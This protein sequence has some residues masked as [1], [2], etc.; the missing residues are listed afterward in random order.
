MKTKI[1][2]ENVKRLGEMIAIRA[3]KTVTRYSGNALDKLY[4]GLIKDINN[5][6][7]KNCI[8]SDG[9]DIAQTAICFLCEHI[10]KALTD[11]IG[12]KK[13][14]DIIT[15]IKA[16]YRV[17]DKYITKKRTTFYETVCLDSCGLE[18]TVPFENDVT[19]TDYSSVDETIKKM[20]LT[21]RQTETL[22]YCMSGNSI[23]ET[24]RLLSLNPTTVWRS[25][26]SIRKKY[27]ACYG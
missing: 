22:S 13:N 5:S 8:F 18:T 23:Y 24:A 11:L 26:V 21:E 12:T 20:E 6:N 17:T 19:L 15:V 7:G 9:Y 10:G 1:T 3:L 14:G 4:C 25:M 2:K 27:I 16:C